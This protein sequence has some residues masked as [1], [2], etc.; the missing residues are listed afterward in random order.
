[1]GT[2]LL[3][4]PF[5]DDDAPID[6]SDFAPKPIAPAKAK[7]AVAVTEAAVEQTNFTK[8]PRK[9]GRAPKKGAY[10]R[11]DR[12]RTGR[13]KLL[14][15]KVTEDD[16]DRFIEMAKDRWVNG[17]ALAYAL[18]ALQEKLDNPDDPFWETHLFHGAD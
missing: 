10:L 8:E 12:F 11:S 16:R 6:L 9:K 17:Q 2:T 14:S 7:A 18:D 1:M 15:V 3:D 5:A 13:D 4:D